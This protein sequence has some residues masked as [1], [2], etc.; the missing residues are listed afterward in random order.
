MRK[1]LL[2]RLF[3]LGAIPKKLRPQL[4]AEGIVIAEEGMPGWFIARNFKAP[5]RRYRHRR[6]GF[7]GALVVTKKRILCTTF[8]RLQ[9]NIGVDDPRIALLRVELPDPET[10]ALSFEASDFHDDQQGAL[11]FRFRTDSA[12]EFYTALNSALEFGNR[13]SAE[14][15]AR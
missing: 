2:Y 6:E 11:E 1:S 7:S 3:G 13:S 9:I 8:S 12:G 4:E 14:K 5:R 15:P 10:L